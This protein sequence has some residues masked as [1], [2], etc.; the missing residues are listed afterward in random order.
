M[1]TLFLVYDQQNQLA[2]NRLVEEFSSKAQALDV[3]VKLA[4]FKDL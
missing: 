1:S 2:L 4:D 3:K